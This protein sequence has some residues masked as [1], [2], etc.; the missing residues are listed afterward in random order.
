MEE[1]RQ[2]DNMPDE[3][4]D[5]YVWPDSEEEDDL[6]VATFSVWISHDVFSKEALH[7]LLHSPLLATSTRSKTPSSF[8]IVDIVDAAVKQQEKGI[9]LGRASSFVDVTC[10]VPRDKARWDVRLKETWVEKMKSTNVA[11]HKACEIVNQQK[12]NDTK[13]KR[14]SVDWHV[15]MVKPNSPDQPLHEDDVSTGKGGR[16]YYTLIVPLVDNPKAGGTYFPKL[17]HVFASYGGALMFDGRIEH[18]GLG[19]RSDTTRYF[20]Y[21]AIHTGGDPNCDE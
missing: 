15:Q 3:E 9:P 8:S 6:P 2:I 13:C 11:F 16:C 7:S 21:A 4:W 19:N 17:D 10:I 14:A 18:A 12:K 5:V 20:L 1:K